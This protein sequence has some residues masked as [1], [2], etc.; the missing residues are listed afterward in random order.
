[1][2]TVLNA[3]LQA[4]SPSA[5]ESIRSNFRSLLEGFMGEGILQLVPITAPAARVESEGRPA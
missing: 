4:G 5:E 1:L 2:Q 3:A